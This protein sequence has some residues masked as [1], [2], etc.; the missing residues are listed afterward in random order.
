MCAGGPASSGEPAGPPVEPPATPS[1]TAAPASTTTTL[2]PL[3]ACDPDDVVVPATPDRTTFPRGTSVTV[4]ASAQNRG[5]RP[6][7]GY[8]PGIQFW[9]PAG[10]SE[11]G[12]ATTGGSTEWEPGQVVSKTFEW[13]ALCGDPKHACPAG[14]YT[15]V[16][17]FGRSRSEPTPFT[18]T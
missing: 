7:L 18:L 12:T 11:G 4:V 1:T 5:S 10:T 8:D 14:T 6:C 15:V 9:N 16:V 3:T 17:F 2:A 13:P